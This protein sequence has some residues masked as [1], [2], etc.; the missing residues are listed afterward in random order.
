MHMQ[1]FHPLNN[2]FSLV[3]AVV[4]KHI[5]AYCTKVYVEMPLCKE[6]SVL[7][8]G[9]LFLEWDKEGIDGWFRALDFQMLSDLPHISY[10]YDPAK[11][12]HVL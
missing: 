3:E 8:E 10:I 1:D 7:G 5:A 9:I 6:L 4:C 11:K 2:L 12:S